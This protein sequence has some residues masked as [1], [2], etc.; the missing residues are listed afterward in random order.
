MT[1]PVLFETRTASNGKI[2]AIA[3]L[4]APNTLNALSLA[5]VDAL[6]A[7]LGAWA[8]DPDIAMVVLQGAGDRALCAGGDLQGL[9]RALTASGGND[10]TA[11]ALP[12]SMGDYV[13]GFFEREYR[14]DHFL[15]HYPKPLLCWGH[16]VVM[17]GGM[18]LMAGASHR[19]VTQHSR[20]AMPEV[21][22]GLFPDVGGSWFLNRVPGNAGLFLALTG[23]PL[24]AADALF[25]GWADHH[26]MQEH[27]PAVMQALV[28]Q[29]WGDTRLVNDAILTR[30]LVDAHTVPDPAEGALQ[31]N[32]AVIRQICAGD[33]LEAVVA[34]IAQAADRDPW[35]HTAAATLAAGA[36][37]TVRLAYELLRRTR[38]LSLAE[39]FR[40]EFAAVL[41]CTAQ[42]DIVEGIRALLI[43]KDR[44]PRWQPATLAEADDAWVQPFFAPPAAADARHP[45]ADLRD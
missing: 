3:T 18:G 29:E 16:G 10:V 31:R 43:D 39:V 32:L 45:L 9:Y 42:P 28:D 12:P 37:G 6:H 40:I 8:T 26:V 1:A 4:N 23:S 2:V 22:I 36:P 13:T 30:V 44:N 11:L 41:H 7:Q 38:G 24:R 34:G 27:R 14:L 5:M 17:G 25:A 15:H 35:L 21:S 33:T 19:V 20:L